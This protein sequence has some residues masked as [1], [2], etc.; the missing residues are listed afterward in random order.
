MVFITGA[1]S[2]I[3]RATALAFAKAGYK[4]A[5]TARRE[6]RLVS[7]ADEIRTLTGNDD[8]FLS[9]VSDVTNADSV[10]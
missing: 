4:V 3:G 10:Q 2:G 9:L 8:Y 6:D 1:S 5:G 7:L